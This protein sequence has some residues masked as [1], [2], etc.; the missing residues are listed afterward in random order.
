MLNSNLAQLYVFI[1]GL[2]LTPITLLFSK[3]TNSDY[4]NC[5]FFIFWPTLTTVTFAF[6]FYS[7]SNLPNLCTNGANSD[8]PN[9]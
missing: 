1:F 9:L 7:N 8:L 5:V 3:I 2:T 4:R 6:Y